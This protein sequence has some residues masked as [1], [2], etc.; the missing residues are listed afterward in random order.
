M[1]SIIGEHISDWFDSYDLFSGTGKEKIH[2][3]IKQRF[4]SASNKEIKE[5]EDYLDSFYEYCLKYADILAVKYKSPYLRGS[6]GN[7]RLCERMSKEI[8]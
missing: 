4:P 2:N 7:L 6:K 5:A 8:P 3:S 1:N